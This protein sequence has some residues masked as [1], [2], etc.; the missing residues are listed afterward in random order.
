MSIKKKLFTSFGT[1]IFILIALAAFSVIQLSKI[2]NNYTYLIDDRA[3]KVLEASKVQNAT[4]LQGLYIRSYVLRQDSSDLDSLSAQRKIVTQTISE[5]EPLFK[6]EQMKKEIQNVKDQQALYN[7]YVEK[8]I[9]YV[10]ND[11]NDKATNMLFNFAVPTNK[12]I[13]QSI[14]NIVDFQTEQM[15]TSSNDTSDS[16]T[17]S[18]ILLIVISVVGTLL[19]IILA[20]MIT[21]NI[22]IPLKHVT[23]SANIIATGDLREKDIV[24]NTKD[25]INDLAQA[26]N[27]MKANLSKLISSVSMNVSNTTAVAEQLAA[28][29]DEVMVATKDIA[30]RMEHIASAGGQAAVTGNECAIATDES[31]QGVGRIA[32]AAQSL[33][34][35]A[36]D[37]QSMATEGGQTLQTAEQ[38]MSVIQQSS[39]ETRER[40]KQLSMQSTEIENITKVITDITEQ[41][42]LLALNAAIEAARAG[43]HG[44]GFAVVADEVRKL[45][46]ES[47]SS[48]SKI[49]ELTSLIQK[50]TKTVEESVN[51]TVQNV[52]QGV[53]YLQNAQASFSNIFGSITEMTA[54]IQEVSA[55]T[56]EISASTEEV[57]ASVTEMAQAANNAAEQSSLILASAEEQSA[58]I[59][60]INSVAKSLSEDAMTIHEEISKFNV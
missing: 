29:T 39:H 20:I 15:N 13:Q 49:V 51:L 4:S 2:D 25:E 5:I 35:K 16:A 1:I 33:H 21:R 57:A 45:A 52:D 44:K 9:Q 40:I 34:S 30:E 7:G 24:V 55:S 32:E 36:I 56:E 19:A 60:E 8:I 50:D 48:A 27:T 14:N 53:A 38:Q 17:F 31:A 12:A 37:M 59:F 58:T 6:D 11:Q 43:E 46:E 22:T 41:T 54:Q 26:F 3:Y 28:S 10:N 47:K 18:K 42:N 23:D